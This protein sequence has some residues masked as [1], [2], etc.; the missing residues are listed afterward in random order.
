MTE[1]NGYKVDDNIQANKVY[2]GN[3]PYCGAP[4]VEG[5]EVCAYCGRK[6]KRGKGVPRAKRRI[7]SGI[8][9]QRQEQQLQ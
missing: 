3:C 6:I 4:L 2:N 5:A 7:R 1:I 9:C 8:R